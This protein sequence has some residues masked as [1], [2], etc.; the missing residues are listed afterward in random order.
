MMHHAAF[1]I[2]HSFALL[3]IVV[4]QPALHPESIPKTHITIA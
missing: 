1:E 4:S 3:G 2:T